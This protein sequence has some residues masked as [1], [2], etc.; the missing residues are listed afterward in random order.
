M[1]AETLTLSIEQVQDYEFRVRWAKPEHAGL[2]V[3]EPAPLGRDS[4]PSPSALLAAAVGNCLTASL[5]F[6][7]RK[8]RIESG[9]IKATVKT[10]VGRNERGRVRVK[11]FEVEIDPGLSEGDR[12]RA[13]RCIALF[14]D[15]C[16]VTA[17]VREGIVVDARIVG[18]EK[19]E[20]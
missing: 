16:T 19:K 17:A 15:F 3:D 7:F 5:L 2:L 6:C 10:E 13:E 20:D 8:S 14:E 12:A 4:A 1:S 18:F 9:P 11:R